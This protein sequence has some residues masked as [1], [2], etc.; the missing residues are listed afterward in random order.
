V[1]ELWVRIAHASGARVYTLLVAVATL[2]VTARWLGP[3]GRGVLAAV[4]TWV[5]LFSTFGSLSLGQVAI[6]RATERRGEP[7]LGESLGTLLLLTSLISVAGWGI[8]ALLWFTTGGSVY[9]GIAPRLLAVGFAMLPFLLWEQYGSSLL[10]A[11]DRL[12][13]YNN[14]QFV[15]RT[16]G[17]LVIVA[18]AAGGAGVMGALIGIV[19]SQVVVGAAGIRELFRRA[20][21]AARASMDTLRGMV[22]SGM[23]LHL[24]AVGMFLVMST[25]VLIINYY[26]GPAETGYYQL[27]SQ[28]VNTM[29]VVPQAA[30]MVFYGKVAQLGADGAWP[31]HRKMIRALMLAAIPLA[32]IAAVLAPFVIPLVG[33]KSFA[34][35]ISP[36]RWLLLA[37]LGMTFA[38][39]LAPQWIGRGFFWQASLLTGALGVMNLVISLLWVPK[40]GIYGSVLGTVI[41]YAVAVVI[42]GWMF[43]YCDRGLRPA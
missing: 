29:L 23:K 20:E 12:S 24:N 4:T 11:I 2:V 10:T 18:M 34:P 38:T 30:A 32:A 5:G 7:W 22:G 14:A 19:A 9:H 27:A 33:G 3:E 43:V 42:N 26:R 8:A 21:G 35:A 13:V 6:H 39:L 31:Y 37:V 41:T 28:L 15:G 36:F 40:Y 25:D 16:I 1:R 17:L